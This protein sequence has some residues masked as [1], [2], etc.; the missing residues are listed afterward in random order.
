MSAPARRIADQRF[1]HDARLRSSQFAG[2]RRS[3]PR[4]RRRPGRRQGWVQGT[5]SPDH[6]DDVQVRAGRLDHQDVGTLLDVERHLA[7][8]LARVRRVH[9]VAAAVAEGR[10]AIAPPRGTGRRSAEAYLTAY[11]RIGV[12]TWPLRPRARRI[13][14]TR[15]SIMSEGATMSAPASPCDSAIFAKQVERGVVADFALADDRRSGRG[16]CI[17]RGRRR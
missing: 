16:W 1:H 17:R 11:E 12:F 14:A 15:P 2:G 9:L 6:P 8:R 5:A 7:Q 3:G 10:R 13:A 4:T